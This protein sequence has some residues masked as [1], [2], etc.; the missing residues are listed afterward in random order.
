MILNLIFFISPVFAQYFTIDK[1]HS[2][3]MIQENS[4]MIFKETIDVKFHQPRHGIYR[5]IPFRYTDELGAKIT[6]PTRILSVADASGKAWKYDV[7]KTG[8][9]IHVRIGD[10]KRYVDGNQTY[11][12]T[13]EV[14]NAILFLKDHDELYWN[15]TGNDWKAP[16]Q[17]ASATV[18][19][20]TKNK[21]KNLM[22]AGYEGV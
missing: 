4:S 2:D 21:S 18:S 20:I 5:E 14:E 16:I 12:I 17:E 10:A 1:F 19:L 15:V 3:I 6:T 13:Y 8:Q 9:V 11:V 7:E 22:A